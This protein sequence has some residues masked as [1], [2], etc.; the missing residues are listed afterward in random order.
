MSSRL[1]ALP[2]FLLGWVVAAQSQSPDLKFIADTVVVQADGT[3]AADP[4]LATMTF[5]IFSQEKE[6]KKAYEAASQSIQQIST[7]GANNALKKEDISTGCSQWH[8][9]MKETA[10]SGRVPIMFKERWS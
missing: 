9:F 5:R 3:Y 2:L 4:D 8:R 6:P 10:K 7:L 1:I